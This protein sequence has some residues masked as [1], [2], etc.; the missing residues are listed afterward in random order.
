MQTF[1]TPWAF[2]VQACTKYWLILE[3]K[4]FLP[5]FAKNMA[6]KLQ[7]SIKIR[8]V[9]SRKHNKTEI[10]KKSSDIKLSNLKFNF[11]PEFQGN[12]IFLVKF[13]LFSTNKSYFCIT[14]WLFALQQLYKVTSFCLLIKPTLKTIWEVKILKNSEFASTK[15]CFLLCRKMTIFWKY[16]FFRR[17]EWYNLS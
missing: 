14:F 17:F 15:R 3:I 16:W 6:I 2:T 12:L 11:L 4:I 10:C 1:W 7:Y 13:D 5:I 8:Y 9:T